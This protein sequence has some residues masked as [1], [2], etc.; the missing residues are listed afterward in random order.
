VGYHEVVDNPMDFGT[1][2]KKISSGE[3]GEGSTAA[4][5]L[6]GDFLLVFNNCS[7]Y[8]PEDSEV[9]EEAARIL[10]LLPETY[11]AACTSVSK[12]K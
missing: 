1:M 2:K 8:N 4:A 12:K 9:A 10:A 6:F 3:Y 5:A 11:A 7:L